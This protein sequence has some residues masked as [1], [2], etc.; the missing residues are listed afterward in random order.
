MSYRL[1]VE[2]VSR[3]RY[4]RPVQSSYNEAR[5]TPLTTPRQLVLDSRVTVRPAAALHGYVDYWG[6]VVHS[7]DL[8]QPHDEMV[9][10][11][12]SVVETA[13]GVGL[14]GR[15]RPEVQ[16][17]WTELA[18]PEVADEYAEYLAPT[19]MVP[20]DNRLVEL[21]RSF[22]G[23]SPAAAADAAIGWVRDQLTYVSGTTGVHTSAVEAWEGGKGVC[24]DYAHLTLAVL[25]GAGV[26]ARYCSGYVHPNGDAEVGETVHGE[27]HAWIE[28]WAGSWVAVDPTAGKSIG[29]RHVLVARGRDYSDVAPVKGIFHGGTTSGL[30]VTVALTR[31]A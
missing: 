22:T 28:Y 9:L 24:Q 26:P 5:L 1:R 20:I 11:G 13:T 10:T 6:T 29:D 30:D 14:D 8:Q 2:H 4:A 7:F 21:G 12:S 18:T 31:L 19:V 25:R 3:Y 17:G 23:P 16:L 15:L 27:S